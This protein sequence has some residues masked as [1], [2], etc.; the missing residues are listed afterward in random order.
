M[1]LF[2]KVKEYMVL[3][4]SSRLKWLAFVILSVTA[5]SAHSTS[6]TAFQYNTMQNNEIELVFQLS[7]NIIGQPNVKTSMNPARIDINFAGFG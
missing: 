3:S 5:T 2:K 4:S 7:E 6:L 1:L